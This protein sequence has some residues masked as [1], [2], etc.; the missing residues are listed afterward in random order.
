M[1]SR[2]VENFDSSKTF[3]RSKNSIH[4][5]FLL[6]EN[7]FFFH[8]KSQAA[9][10]A[11]FHRSRDTWRAAGPVNKA[12]TENFDLSEFSVNFLIS[13][14]CLFCCELQSCKIFQIFQV[15]CLQLLCHYYGFQFSRLQSNPQQLQSTMFFT[16]SRISVGHRWR[17]S[18]CIFE[19]MHHR[20]FDDF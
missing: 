18:D 1:R 2:L 20:I 10:L 3:D 17:V 9:Q 13:I 14:Q 19:W 8:F 11:T 15:L 5:K 12:V 6:A 4:R 7:H 16:L